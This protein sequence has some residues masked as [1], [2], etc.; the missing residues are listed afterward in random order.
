[1]TGHYQHDPAVT[2]RGL[3]NVAAREHEHRGGGRKV[4]L[5]SETLTD[6]GIEFKTVC[7]GCGQT[8]ATWFE[9]WA[10]GAA[11]RYQQYRRT[12]FCDFDAILKFGLAKW[13]RRW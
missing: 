4:I 3:A 8:I 12:G 6:E 7:N 11:E 5:E 1:M 13:G 9:R 2:C 10:P